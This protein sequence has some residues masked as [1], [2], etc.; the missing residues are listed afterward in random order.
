M[1][2]PQTNRERLKEITAQIEHGIQEL[3]QS[4]RFADYLR[5]MSKFHRYSINNTILIHMQRPN[6]TLVAGYNKWKDQFQRHVRRGEKGITII[7]PTPFKKKVEEQKLDPDTK[8]PI[9]DKDGNVVMVE[10]EI[11]IPLFKPMKVFDVSQTEGKPLPQLANDLT[12]AVQHYEAFLEALRRASPVPIRFE[13]MAANMDGYFDPERQGIALRTGMSEVQTVSAAVH[14]MA[15]ATL[16]NY[17]RGRLATVP[18]GQDLPKPKDRNTEEVEAESVSYAVCQF[19][20]IETGANSFGY[21]ASWSK[22]K[23]LPELKASLDT[24]G[25]TA[26]DLIITV[27]RHFREVC[28]ELGIDLTPPKPLDEYPLPTPGLTVA[29]L[30]RRGY[31]DGDLLPVSRETAEKLCGEGCGIFA[32][33]STGEKTD[34]DHGWAVQDI[35]EGAVYAVS[36]ISWE[37]TGLFDRQMRELLTRQ[38]EREKA[39]LDYPGD[40]FAVYHFTG[41]PQG[42]GIDRRDYELAYTAKLPDGL[43]P[44]EALEY[45]RFGSGELPPYGAASCDVIALRQDGELSCH[46]IDL[47]AYTELSGFLTGDGSAERTDRTIPSERAVPAPEQGEAAPEQTEALYLVGEDTYLHLQ[48]TDGGYDYTLYDR[49]SGKET[50]G[51]QL[52]APD[53]TLEA[54]RGEVLALHDLSARPVQPVSLEVL[55]PP[56]PS[57]SYV[58]LL[59]HILPEDDRMW[60]DP[61]PPEQVLDEYPMPDPD[62]TVADLERSGYLDGDMLPLSQERAKELFDQDLTVY[63]IVDGGAAEMMLDQGDIEAL[64]LDTVFAV[65]R[66]EWEDSPAFDAQVQERMDHQ[67]EREAAFLA[68]TGDCFAIYQMRDG[69]DLARIRFEGMDWLKSVGETVKRENYELVYTAPLPEAGSTDAALEALWYQFNNDHPAD[70]HHPSMSVS[71]IVAVKRDGEVSC[72][73]VD[74]FGFTKVEGFLGDNPLKNAEMALEDDYGMIDGIINNGPRQPTVADLEAQV[75]AGQPISLM[76]L[77]AAAHRED[78]EKKRSVVERLKSQPRQERK[79]S[80]PKKSAEREI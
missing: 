22:D 15:H 37:H 55:D 40:C 67:P 63:A 72:H 56:P 14:E 74:S 24:I 65:D 35:P 48:A 75:K 45:V 10:R 78:R 2:G 71:D 41:E 16:H 11:E 73:Y 50:D 3:F 70:Y 31:R 9:L 19:F 47:L 6:A 27:S 80:A 69:D 57:D 17:E 34:G 59:E 43:S 77:A 76:D 12:G 32:I 51:G 7:A 54:A 23:S 61:V 33:L 53:L 4:E 62:L 36:R 13:A 25:R 44:S 26:N 49:T 39:F 20:G 66:E 5:T 28:K 21:I 42:G 30:E 46:Y 38:E 79:K 1:A 29:E 18:E 64:P 58:K 8:A 68:H 60:E 52:D